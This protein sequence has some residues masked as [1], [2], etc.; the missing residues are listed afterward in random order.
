ME[1]V[2]SK[3]DTQGHIINKYQFKIL[4]VPQKERTDTKTAET[5]AAATPKREA[6]SAEAAEF[7]P[8]PRGSRDELVESLL[9]KTDD[10]SSNFIKLQMKLEAAEDEYKRALES[11]RA[12]AYE[13]GFQAGRAQVEQEAS[14]AK[15]GGMEQLAQSLRTLEASAQK[16]E[17]A[18]EG[19][20]GE[21]MHAALDIAKEVVA[22]EVKERS[23]EIASKLS[24]QLIKELQ[25]ASKV[26][27][28][29]NPADHGPISEKVGSLSHIEV[30]S[31]GA[32]SPGGV[33]AISDAGNIDAEIMKRYE[34][35]KRAALSE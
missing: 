30:V 28:R 9:K 24:E 20:K 8:M 14:Q 13:A 3:E 5:P 33:I 23:G 7:E 6:E 35:A 32:V 16:F 1:V 18:L 25:S 31:D 4:G 17:S 10:I 34:R 19:I 22:S 21:L 27:L 29:V 12:E 11:A 15:S 2:I 26:T